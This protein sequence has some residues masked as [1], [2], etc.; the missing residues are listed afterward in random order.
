MVNGKWGT[1][2]AVSFRREG[3]L[4]VCKGMS[5]GSPLQRRVGDRCAASKSAARLGDYGRLR[6]RQAQGDKLGKEDTALHNK[7]PQAGT[8]APP[9][10]WANDHRLGQSTL[11]RRQAARWDTAPYR[12]GGREKR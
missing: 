11:Q 12:Q 6:L 5:G 8:P 2:G 1:A 7:L 4:L 3:K 9:F 10:G